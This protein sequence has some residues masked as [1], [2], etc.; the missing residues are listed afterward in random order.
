MVRFGKILV[1]IT[2]T[3][4]YCLCLGEWPYADLI[5]FRAMMLPEQRQDSQAGV[6]DV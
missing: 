5:V 2:Q 6:I 1:P 4:G 3:L